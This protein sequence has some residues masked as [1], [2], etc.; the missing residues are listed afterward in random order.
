[1]EH[2]FSGSAPT[3]S[4]SESNLKGPVDETVV[5]ERELDPAGGV[6]Q[7]FMPLLR[8]LPRNPKRR[9]EM[10]SGFPCWTV[11]PEKERERERKIERW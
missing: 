7:L 9:V 6:F 1:M 10:R 2:V 5:A 4:G 8:D 11:T 3:L